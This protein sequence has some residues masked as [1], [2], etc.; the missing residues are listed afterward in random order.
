MIRLTTLALL[1]LLVPIVLSLGASG[2]PADLG[3]TLR[4]IDP[5]RI[6]TDLKFL[7]DDLLEGRGTGQRGGRLAAL[8]LETRFRQIGLAPGASE[9]GYLQ[10]VPLVGVESGEDS[11]LEF[12]TRDQ[13]L[14]PERLVDFVGNSETQQEVTE[15]E[16]PLVFAGYGIVAPEQRW[17]DFKGADLKGKVLVLLVNDPPSEDPSFFGGKALTYYGRWTYKFES[18]ARAGA[19][20][21]I[22]IHTDASAGYGWS[23]VRNSWGRERPY[24]A[25]RPGGAA[26]LALAS[27]VSES[28]GRRMLQAAGQDFDSLRESASR[29]DFRPV[30]LGI[31]LAARLTSRVRPI[32]TWNVIGRIPGSD[33]RLAREAVVFTAHYDHLG[34]G[35]PE[36][37]D[38]IYNGAADNASGVATLLE[39]ARAF[40]L[41]PRAPKRTLLFIACAAEEGG[42]RGSEYYASHPAIPAHLTAANI[43][44]DGLPVWGEPRD[45]TFLGADRSSL[46]KVIADAAATLR[47]RIVP[48]PHPEQGSFYRSDQFSLAKV[49]IPA[50]SIDPGNEYIGKPDGYGDRIWEEYE[51]RQYHRPK[52]EYDAAFDL[53]GTAAVARIALYTGYRIAEA[54]GMP[55]WNA[56]DEFGAARA[57][58]L[59][60]G[61]AP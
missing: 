38:A 39:T 32:A 4:R 1:L 31:S 46:M 6:R 3:A 54:P 35:T 52:D 33:P 57:R 5:E 48:D 56:G 50:F 41:L 55:Q 22:L 19:R 15:I 53:A 17:D 42:L 23:V 2:P 30:P 27:W 51:A 59:A 13:T 49:G 40:T 28:F 58:S 44:M 20:G 12:R 25:L 60:A 61:G 21:A 18:A 16:A 36:E 34:V 10:D 7:A 9:T 47:F 11:R 29:R 45:F 14:R 24:M 26:P 8:Y 43:N 37:G